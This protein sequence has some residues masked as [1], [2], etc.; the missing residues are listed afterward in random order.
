M[1]AHAFCFDEAAHR[2]H[3]DKQLLMAIAKTESGFRPN[4]YNINANGSAD[5][6]LMQ[7]NDS[8][9]PT[10]RKWGIDRTR[11]FD[12][13]TNVNV[14]AWVLANNFVQHGRTWKAVGAYNARSTDKQEAYAMRV[15][16]NLNI[17]M[18]P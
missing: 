17:G 18:R 4:A 6:G 15:W 5:I 12:P 1:S 2:Y 11:L 14:G 9:L 8:W 16:K 10:L 7:I 13:C 3:V